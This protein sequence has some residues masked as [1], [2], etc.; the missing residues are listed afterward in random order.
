MSQDEQLMKSESTSSSPKRNN[1]WIFIAVIAILLAGNIYLFMSRN[2]AVE[3]RDQAYIERDTTQIVMESVQG[4]YDAALARL[5]NLTSKNAQLDSMVNGKDSEIERLRKQITGILGNS[6]STA[7]DLSRARLL[8]SQLNTTVKGYEE[9]IAELRGENSRLTEFN[10]V[11]TKERDS[12]V[13]NNIALQQKVKLGAVLHVSN[14]RMA[15]IDLRRGG[16][17]ERQTSKAKNVDI[18]RITFDI[19][20]NR[21]ADDGVKDLYIRITSPSGTLLSNAAYGSGNTSTFNGE[22]L[23]YTVAKQIYLKKDEPVKNVTVD[24]NQDNNYA[25]GNYNIEIYNEGRKVGGGSISL[26]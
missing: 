13:A 15:P 3:E 7:K 12:T 20:E 5:D 16:T 23:N 17:R 9:Q 18:F 25:K 26:K 24:W 14:I 19:D 1:T 10:E 6:R 2:T 11:V 22:T 8:I 21:I 4:E